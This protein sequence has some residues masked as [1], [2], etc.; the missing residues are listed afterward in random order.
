MGITSW[1]SFARV[2][3]GETLKLRELDYVSAARALGASE[4]RILVRHILPNLMHLVVITFALLFSG[5]VLSEAILSF[6]GIGIDGSWGQM[7]DQARD[8]LARD[9]II[10]WN[11]AAASSALF[12]LILSVNLVGD[13]IRD[14]LDPRTVRENL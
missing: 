14:I 1:V 4:L 3:R 10:A 7:I 8:E 13:T 6:L 9:P 11:L 5:T 12:F 2:V